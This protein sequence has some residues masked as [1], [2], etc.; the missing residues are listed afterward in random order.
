M[1]MRCGKTLACIDAINSDERNFPA[2][3]I[4]PLSVLAG[5]ENELIA[6]GIPREQIVK[7][8]SDGKSP[9]Q[10]QRKLF[11]PGAR[12]FLTNYEQ[13][14]RINAL[15]ARK[16]PLKGIGL[17][18]WGSIT[19]DESYRLSN[20]E[21]RLFEYLTRYPATPMHQRRY[22]LSGAPASE[23]ALD[24]AAQYIFLHG[25][26]FGCRSAIAYK[27]KFWAWNPYT[28]KWVVRDPEHLRDIL[29]YVHATAYCTTLE[30]LGLGGKKLYRVDRVEMNAEQKK[31]LLWLKTATVYDKKDGT[32]GLLDALV[33]CTFEAKIS[34]GVHPLTNEIISRSKIEHAVQL[35]ADHPEQMLVLSRFRAPITEAEAAF[36]TAGAKVSAITGSTSR[37]ERERIRLEFQSGR[38]DVIV[39]QVIPVKMGL[40]FSALSRVIYLSNSFSQD[41]RSQSEDRG[42]HAQRTTPYEIIDICTEGTHDEILTNVLTVKRENATLYV[43]AWNNDLTSGT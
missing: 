34:T 31:Q 26:Y 8:V 1:K 18:E 43:K 11:H 32:T 40:D 15:G 25:E 5:W 38:L 17:Q 9:E 13:L 29:K 12:Y 19:A 39:A 22:I 28:F 3:I 33:R 23:N 7:I 2:L 24:F 27:E 10:T 6:D 20:D 35:W 21:G 36:A 42:Q 37:I 14:K 30:D 16:K 4:G 41:D